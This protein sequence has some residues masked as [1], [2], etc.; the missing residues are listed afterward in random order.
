MLTQPLRAHSRRLRISCRRAL[1]VQ[2]SGCGNRG[3]R[4]FMLPGPVSIVRSQP[5]GD[6][7]REAG[8]S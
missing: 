3:P 8:E 1:A 2:F 5:A 6:L 4:G 7:Q